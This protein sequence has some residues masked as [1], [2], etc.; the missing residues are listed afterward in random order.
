MQSPLA[1]TVAGNVGGHLEKIRAPIAYRRRLID[2]QQTRISF[3]CNVLGLVGTRDPSPQKRAER[4]I[5]LEKQFRK[6]RGVD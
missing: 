6:G 1:R 4:S 2:L 3:L 5:V